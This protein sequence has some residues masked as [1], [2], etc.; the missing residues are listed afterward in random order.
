MFPVPLAAQFPTQVQ[1][2][3]VMVD[4]TV[5]VTVA[6]VTALGPAF[7]TTIVYVMGAPGTAVVCP[8]V[9]VI[10]RSAIAAPRVTLMQLV[11]TM[12]WPSG[13][14]RV[15]SLR[16]SVVAVTFSVT[17]VGLLKVTLLTVTP[18]LTLACRR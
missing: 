12:L 15:T 6:P 14:V 13:L 7:D 16:P 10:D 2:A 17:D 9:F 5:S 18:P 4:G 11:P 8:S 1:L 3:P